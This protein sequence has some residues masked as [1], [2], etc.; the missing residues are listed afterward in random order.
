MRNVNR[1]MTAAVLVAGLLATAGCRKSAAELSRSG[2]AY[3]A[4]KR[5]QEAIIEYRS[6]LQKNPKIGETRLKLAKVYAEAGDG[7]NAAREY[8][9]AADL[10][11]HDTAAQM[12]AAQYLYLSHEFADARSRAERVLAQDPKNVEA[13]ILKAN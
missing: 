2:D 9:R 1:S 5:Y 3:A 10:L 7:G 8:V 12:K 4:Q 6:A 11:P 13:Q